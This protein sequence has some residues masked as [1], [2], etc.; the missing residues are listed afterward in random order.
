MRLHCG[1]LVVLET[2]S[3]LFSETW[4]VD[5]SSFRSRLAHGL[6]NTSGNTFGD[7][8]ALASRLDYG[9]SDVDVRQ[10]V[11]GSIFY[12]LPFG[13]TARGPLGLITK[14]WQLN[15]SGVWSTGLP[16]TVANANNVSNTNPGAFG[17]DRPNQ[18]ASAALANPGVSRFFNTAA[19][20]AQN[21]GSLGDER[22]NQLYGPH[23]RRLDVSLFK[24]FAIPQEAQLQFRAEAFNVTN[25]ANFAAPASILGA[26]NFGR[27]TQLT[28]GY[29]PREVQFAARLHF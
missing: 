10:R 7:F 11:A 23:N 13:K 15:L 25:T 22:N 19:F 14:S 20:V 5:S 12:E 18:I 16:F 21:P 29:N 6:D 17:L 4:K 8:P 27:F 2:N 1:A 3:K 9:N 24:N 28:A 26:A